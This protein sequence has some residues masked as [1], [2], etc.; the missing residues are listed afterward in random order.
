MRNRRATETGIGEITTVGAAAV[1]RAAGAGQKAAEAAEITQAAQA[2]AYR[3]M[4][5]DGN[6]AAV[7]RGRRDSE[8]RSVNY[9]CRI[10]DDI[11]GHGW[12]TGST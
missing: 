7:R 12:K 1:M 4:N 3:R 5:G 6:R 2:G 8:V 10:S 11:R 9:R